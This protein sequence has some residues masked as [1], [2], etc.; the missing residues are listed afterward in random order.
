[1]RTTTIATLMLAGLL[2][3][4]LAAPLPP[5]VG[6]VMTEREPAYLVARGN[7]TEARVGQALVV[8]SALQ[9]GR[10][11]ALGITFEDGTR[12]ALGP[13]SEAE[14]LEYRFDPANDD[15]ALYL[16]MRR[17]TLSLEPGRLARLP[18]DALRIETG[19]GVISVQDARMLLKVG[20]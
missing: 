16:R 11:G 20:P 4:A 3:P 5:P 10:G 18:P 14:L 2:G 6:Y 19:R 8:G 7:P 13:D 1:M 12:L 15:L 9:T 17:G